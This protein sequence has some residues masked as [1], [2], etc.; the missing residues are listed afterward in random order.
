[1]NFEN[2][3]KI[4]KEILDDE[5]GEISANYLLNKYE[6]KHDEELLNILNQIKKNEYISSDNK[7]INRIISELD[8]NDN[9]LDI[10][11]IINIKDKVIDYNN[12]NNEDENTLEKND[13]KEETDTLE[14]IIEDKSKNNNI[15]DK[16]KGITDNKKNLG[17]YA[18]SLIVA[19]GASYFVFSS[20]NADEIKNEPI[21]LASKEKTIEIKKEIPIIVEEEKEKIIEVENDVNEEI[22]LGENKEEETE[23][24]TVEEVVSVV[25]EKKEDIT[26]EINNDA[27]EV[28]SLKLKEEV[29][30]EKI[31][32]IEEKKEEIQIETKEVKEVPQ[33]S[34]QLNSLNDIIKYQKEL[35]YENNSINFRDSLYKEGDNLFGFKIFKLTPIYVKFEDTKKSI[36]K[37]V[38]LKK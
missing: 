33:N 38:R 35:K 36:R 9:L 32:V 7:V 10:N 26:E 34:I 17:I 4:Y 8:S 30:E 15:I 19:I 5:N 29:F 1:M 21:I 12:L 14:K 25:E 31:P 20:S 6:I 2:Y 24:K 37:R 3:N 28:T 11:E 27:K 22:T 16:Q 13:K 18:A 23:E